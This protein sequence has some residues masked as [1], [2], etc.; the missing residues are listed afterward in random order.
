M[1]DGREPVTLGC[2]IVPQGSA[3][4]GLGRDEDAIRAEARRARGEIREDPIADL[5]DAAAIAAQID[6]DRSGA[7][8]FGEHG[9]DRRRPGLATFERA[10]PLALLGLSAPERM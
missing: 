4:E 3:R 7:A 6:D 2:Q 8:C 1:L 5:V 9:I 10:Q